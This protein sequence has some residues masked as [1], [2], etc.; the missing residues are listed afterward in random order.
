LKKSMR[1]LSFLRGCWMRCKMIL[2]RTIQ[3]GCYYA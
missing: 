3:K 2:I 1:P